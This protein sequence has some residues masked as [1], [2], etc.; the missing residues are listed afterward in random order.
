VCVLSHQLQDYRAVPGLSDVPP[1]EFDR[2]VN[3]LAPA[4]VSVA[5]GLWSIDNNVEFFWNSMSEKLPCM[6]CI[7]RTYVNVV[8]NSADAE[9]SNSLYNLIVDNRRRSLSE[10]S[11]KYLLFLYYNH[12]VDTCKK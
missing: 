11:I 10:D 2:Y 1:S 3:T 6:T 5:G 9:R 4:A 12:D 7:A 8:C